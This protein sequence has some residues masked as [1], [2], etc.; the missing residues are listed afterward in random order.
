M[1]FGGEFVNE[2][3]QIGKL[4]QKNEQNSL[5]EAKNPC[6]ELQQIR[7]MMPFFGL[8]FEFA[9]HPTENL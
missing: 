4:T 7:T 3:V 1:A 6:L 9:G 5:S 8:G 2:R